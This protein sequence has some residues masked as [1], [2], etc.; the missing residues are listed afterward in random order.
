MVFISASIVQ[1]IYHLDTLITE[2][3]V[4]AGGLEILA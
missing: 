1:F 2:M 4:S 3:Y